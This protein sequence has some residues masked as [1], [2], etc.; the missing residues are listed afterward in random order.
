MRTTNER[1]PLQAECE[2]S[3]KFQHRELECSY[4][5][6]NARDDLV[7]EDQEKIRKGMD[8]ESEYEMWEAAMAELPEDD[9]DADQPRTSIPSQVTFWRPSGSCRM[10]M[11]SKLVRLEPCTARCRGQSCCNCCGK[12]PC[13]HLAGPEYF[14]FQR[15]DKDCCPR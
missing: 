10:P 14:P 2:R 7:I 5:R 1:C 13:L 6:D 11:K 3:C 15:Y 8:R 4:Y 9:L 12:A